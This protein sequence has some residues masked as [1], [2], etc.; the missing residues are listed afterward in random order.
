MSS[1]RAWAAPAPKQPLAPI[2]VEFGALGAEE[3]EV[4]VEHCGLCHSDLSMIDDEWRRSRFPL[5]PG[6]E[7]V[8]RVVAA[9]ASVRR[10][11]VG[12]RV[13]VGWYASSCM[14]CAECLA[15]DAHLC[16]RATETIVGRHGGFAE[17]VRLHWLWATPLPAGLDFAGAGPLFC[18]GITVFSPIVEFGVRP[19][20][21]VAVLG[22]GGL[23]H[24]AVRFL[25]AWGCEV[26]AITSSAA[27]AP[28]VRELG[29]HEVV[30]LDDP[31]GLKRCARRFDFLL[32]TANASLPWNDL[33]ATLAPR[34][35]MHVVGAVLEPIPVPAFALIGGQKSV[36]GSPLGRPATIAR[37]LDFCA[38]HDIRP[39]VERFP[40]SRIN[41]ALAHLRSGKARWRIVLDND[42][43]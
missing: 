24:L 22:I 17:R 8:G 23:G 38:R 40:L 33:L 39:I 13:G 20:D 19:T 2:T 42:Y 26:T 27:K 16:S 4:A 25:R 21:R 31:A 32:V 14:A 12:D 15:G 28:A 35:R 34:G 36:S 30:S 7:A 43:A 6:H 41:Q 9:G 1:V 3:V 29:A 5:V 11:A 10:V 37:M 18:G